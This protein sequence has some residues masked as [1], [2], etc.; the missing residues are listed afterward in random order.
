MQPFNT[1]ATIYYSAPTYFFIKQST[2][3]LIILSHKLINIFFS[4]HWFAIC[5]P[6]LI[7]L[8]PTLQ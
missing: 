2:Q 8:I 6:V 3:H 1:G 7:K 5:L 4:D